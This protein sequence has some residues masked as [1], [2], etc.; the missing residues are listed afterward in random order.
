MPSRMMTSRLLTFSEV[1]L[2]NF[3]DPTESNLKFT[4]QRPVLE[5]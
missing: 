2:P 3:L 5:S 4:I 1:I